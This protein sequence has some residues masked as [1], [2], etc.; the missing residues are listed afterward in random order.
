MISNS[1]IAVPPYNLHQSVSKMGLIR[2]DL[3]VFET[4]F[5][6]F[7]VNFQTSYRFVK[8]PFP[9]NNMFKAIINDV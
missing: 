3:F 2:L 4:F 7:V 6:E 9:I 5:L 8:L 1:P